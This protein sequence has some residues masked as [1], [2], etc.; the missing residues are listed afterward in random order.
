M[1]QYLWFPNAELLGVR[2]FYKLDDARHGGFGIVRLDEVEVALG[3]GRA[4]V[5]LGSALVSSS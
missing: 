5:S 1:S 3:S 4:D 2:V